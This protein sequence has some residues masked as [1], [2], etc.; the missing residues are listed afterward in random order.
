MEL[1]FFLVVKRARLQ[2]D[3]LGNSRVTGKGSGKSQASGGSIA[4][5]KEQLS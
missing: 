4:D 2:T 3:Y 5:H 1:Y